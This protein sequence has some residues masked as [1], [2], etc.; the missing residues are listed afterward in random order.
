MFSLKILK[1][2]AWILIYSVK[3]R[4]KIVTFFSDDPQMTMLQWHAR[5]V[6]WDEMPLNI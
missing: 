6:Q 5:G 2:N 3:L 4:N 1:E